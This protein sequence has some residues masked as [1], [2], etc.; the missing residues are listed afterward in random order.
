MVEVELDVTDGRSAAALKKAGLV[1]E[2]RTEGGTTLVLRLRLP[3]GVLG[4]LQRALDER[5]R[6]RVIEAAVE[7]YLREELSA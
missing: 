6:F 7:P 2:E 5:V 4:S 1:L 3:D